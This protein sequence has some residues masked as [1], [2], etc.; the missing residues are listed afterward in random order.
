VQES[1]QSGMI[2]YMIEL[3][4]LGILLDGEKT[5]YKLK[6]TAKAEYSL[7]TGASFGSI[8]P[9]LKKLEEGEF[10]SSKN[11]ISKGGQKSSYFKIT[12]KGKAKFEELMGCELPESLYSSHQIAGLKIIFLDKLD[13]EKQKTALSSIQNFYENLHLSIKLQLEG[14]VSNKTSSRYKFLKHYEE[15]ISKEISFINFF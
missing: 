12:S 2:I 10:V 3:L 11:K 7:L 9:A 5:I 1:W 14:E 8:H 6:Q 4:I 13:E 15:K